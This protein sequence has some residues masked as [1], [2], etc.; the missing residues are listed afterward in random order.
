MAPCVSVKDCRIRKTSRSGTH[1]HKQPDDSPETPIHVDMHGNIKIQYHQDRP[2]SIRVPIVWMETRLNYGLFP[3]SPRQ[4]PYL[5]MSCRGFEVPNVQPAA[6][7]TVHGPI[8]QRKR[9]DDGFTNM[10]IWH[11]D[12]VIENSNS[13]TKSDRARYIYILLPGPG[14][15][16]CSSRQP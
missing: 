4:Y 16:S 10:V 12:G 5:Q 6:T 14:F 9:G 1:H 13:A 2:H 15:R 3:E 11:A 7:T 8:T